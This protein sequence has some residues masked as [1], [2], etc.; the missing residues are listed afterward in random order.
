MKDQTTSVWFTYACLLTGYIGV[1]AITT[2]QTSASIWIQI[3]GWQAICAGM[4]ML[5][6]LVV[7]LINR[8]K[9]FSKLGKKTRNR[10]IRLIIV[11]ALIVLS[12]SYVFHFLSIERIRG[13]LAILSMFLLCILGYAL[14]KVPKEAVGSTNSSDGKR[15]LK[16]GNDGGN[17]G[18]E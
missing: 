8:Y 1:A 11:V 10:G 3:G 4:L 9:D 6:M 5:S 17:T 16:I 12:P 15:A 2:G 13:V 7:E 18:D 14:N